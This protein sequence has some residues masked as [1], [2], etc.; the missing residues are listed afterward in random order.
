MTYD[1]GKMQSDEM[2]KRITVTLPDAIYSHLGEWAYEE[3]R[4]HTQLANLLIELSVRAKYPD[5]YPPAITE[6]RRSQSPKPEEP[7]K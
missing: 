7:G 6:T 5:R 3:G 1:G 2:S 4:T